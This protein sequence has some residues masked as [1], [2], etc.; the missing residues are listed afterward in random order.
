MGDISHRLIE[1]VKT[2]ALHGTRLNI[3]G[4]G[5]KEFLGRTPAGQPVRVAEHHR[6]HRGSSSGALVPVAQSPQCRGAHKRNVA[7]QHQDRPVE[8]TQL[9]PNTRGCLRIDATCAGS[10]PVLRLATRSGGRSAARDFD[11]R[12]KTM[13]RLVQRDLGDRFR[14]QR[15]ES[16]VSR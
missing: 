7:A 1:Q 8:I 9:A 5:S 15:R 4:R 11:H 12:A 13:A 2:A 10:A 3:V 14:F 16:W 6:E